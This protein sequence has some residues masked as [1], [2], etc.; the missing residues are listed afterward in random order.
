MPQP[1]SY[2]DPEFKEKAMDVSAFLLTVAEPNGP[3]RKKLGPYVL[4]YM[5]ILT[6]LLFFINR[7]TW[8]GVKKTI[9][10]K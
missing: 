6:V 7:L 8:K 1:L 4:A 2:D 3:E 5:F 9:E 10:R